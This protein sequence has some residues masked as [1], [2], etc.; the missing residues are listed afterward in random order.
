VEIFEIDCDDDFDFDDS[1]PWLRVIG[2]GEVGAS[3]VSYFKAADTDDVF[4]TLAVPDKNFLADSRAEILKFIADAYWLFAVADVDDL[5]IAAQVAAGIEQPNY[6]LKTFLILCP[7]AEDVRLADIPDNF[8]TWI[9]LPKDKIAALGL[10]NDEIILR[11]VNMATSIAPGA[12]KRPQLRGGKKVGYLVGRDILDVATV[13][14][15]CGKA[16]IG[17]G[18]SLDAENNSLQ[19]V[20]NALKSPLFIE[21]IRHAKKILIVFVVRYE[22]LSGREAAEASI[23]LRELSNIDPEEAFAILWQADVYE[24]AADGVAAFVLAT[25]FDD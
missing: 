16:C 7:T 11:T 14:G 4:G 15:N 20:K 17:F 24:T 3:A 12:K 21:D 18:E 2:V 22:F 1:F 25:K 9:I 8:G 13:T 23:F 19:A 10:T 5:E 6:K